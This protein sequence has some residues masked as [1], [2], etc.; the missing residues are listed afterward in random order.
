MAAAG[1]SWFETREGALLTMRKNSRSPDEAKRN[2]GIIARC[3]DLRDVRPR[4][5]LRLSGLRIIPA[6]QCR[7]STTAR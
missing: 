3:A 7:G 2:P 4:I 5:V 1:L 6:L